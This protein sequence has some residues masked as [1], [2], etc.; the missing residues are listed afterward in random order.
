V[1]FDSLRVT[2]RKALVQKL[3]LI[4]FITW[5]RHSIHRFLAG[6]TVGKIC[7]F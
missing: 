1:L 4:V 3:Y 6:Q 7:P 5:L 2:T